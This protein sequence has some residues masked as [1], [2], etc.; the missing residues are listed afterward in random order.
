MPTTPTGRLKTQVDSETGFR[1]HEEKPGGGEVARFA[2]H[3]LPHQKQGSSEYCVIPPGRENR[4]EADEG[5][6]HVKYGYGLYME[7]YSFKEVIFRAAADRSDKTNVKHL[8]G[9]HRPKRGQLI[10]IRSRIRVYLNFAIRPVISAPA[11]VKRRDKSAD[12]RAQGWQRR[13]CSMQL[14]YVP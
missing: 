11:K 13:G 14:V 7:V 4:R 9:Q 2:P 5:K 12:Q 1:E 8:N 6:M 10:C 3:S